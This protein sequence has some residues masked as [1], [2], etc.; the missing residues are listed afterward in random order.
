M[1]IDPTQKILNLRN[2]EIMVGQSHD[3]APV[4]NVL[5]VDGKEL[6]IVNANLDGRIVVVDGKPRMKGGKALTLGEAV[7]QL[8]VA[9]Y[10]GDDKLSGTKKIERMELGELFLNE[11]LPVEVSP[12]QAKMLIELAEKGLGVVEYTRVK[13]MVVAAEHA[14]AEAKLKKPI[15]PVK[16]AA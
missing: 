10:E 3:L 2:E 14:A 13:R 1:K 7:L 16:E 11:N 6:V 5:V 8:V 15:K 9:Q 12:D 4:G